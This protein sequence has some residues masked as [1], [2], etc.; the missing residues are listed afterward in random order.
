MG[1]SFWSRGPSLSTT[2]TANDFPTLRL[3]A[4]A[5]HKYAHVLQATLEL[6][7]LLH[8]IH[9]T[10]YAS[11]E[12]RAQMIKRGDY[13]RYLDDFRTSISAWETRWDDLKASPKLNCTMNIFKEYVRLYT[14]AFAL[15]SLISRTAQP[16]RFDNSPAIPSTNGSVSLFPAGIMSTAE[17]SYILE[18]VDAAR[19][20]LSIA[21]RTNL[22]AQICYMPFRFYVYVL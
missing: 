14:N 7:Q 5:E 22:E 17:G 8:N 16:D 9:D 13:N 15:Q 4:D 10:F 11:R 1:Q 12:R 20:I 18:A 2:F 21:V 6:T 3:E 19:Q